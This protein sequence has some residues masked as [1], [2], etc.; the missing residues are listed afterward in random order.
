MTTALDDLPSLLGWLRERRSDGPVVPDAVPGIWHVLGYAE[1]VEVLTDPAAYSSDMSTLIPVH[2]DT[3]WISKG[4]VITMDSP[5]HSRLRALVSGV[6]TPRLVAG[7]R[8]RIVEVTGELLDAVAGRSRFD[9]VEALTHPLPVTVIAELLGIPA[10][11]RELFGK[12]ADAFIATNGGGESP[13]PTEE[14]IKAFAQTAVEMRAYLLDHVQQRRRTPSTDLL[15]RLVAAETEDGRLDDDEIIGFAAALLMAGHITTTAV[16]GNTVLCL[17]EQPAALAALRADRS[18]LPAAIEET[19]RL[20][21]A[22]SRLARLTTRQV[23][24]GGVTLPAAQMLTVWALA[25]N[26]DP[27][28]FAVPDRFDIDREPGRHLGFGQGVHYCLGAPLA[29]LEAQVALGMLLDRCAEFGLDQEKPVGYH[30]PMNVVGPN[31]LPLT[32]RWS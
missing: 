3:A 30:H 15:G 16:L 25:A 2:P 23:E 11:D 24:L 4:S 12:W 27:R 32:A 22:F 19:V 7:L 26:R 31:R 18:R 1:V 14:H 29:R 9:L 6:F 17:A 21:P 20:R 13:L 5:M 8:P 10:R 28:R